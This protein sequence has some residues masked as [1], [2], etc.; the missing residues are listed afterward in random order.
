MGLPSYILAQQLIFLIRDH[1]F[2]I[3]YNHNITLNFT[4]TQPK[5]LKLLFD[6]Q[7]KHAIYYN[8]NID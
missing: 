5:Y 6:P 3:N 8:Q 4:K 2:I 1:Y 7:H